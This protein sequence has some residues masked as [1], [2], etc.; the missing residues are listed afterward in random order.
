MGAALF[1]EVDEGVYAG[2]GVYDSDGT[3]SR[4]GFESAF[5]GRN[6]SVTLVELG[7]RPTWTWDAQ[8]LGG[9]YY[10]GGWYHSGTWERFGEPDRR[11]RPPPTRRGNAGLYVGIDQLV[12][13]ER[14][15]AEDDSQ[16]LGVFGQWGW[17]PSDVN[18]ISGYYGVGAQYV[19]LLPTRDDDVTGLGVFHV[20][21][22]G[23]AQSLEGRYSE[24]AVELFHKFQLTPAIG[25][26]PDLQYI[27][28]PG[29]GGR[30]AVAVGVRVEIS[31]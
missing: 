29:G 22:S 21:L 27:V 19:G 18:E 1:V 9:R 24:T 7:V 23:R 25:V 26:K 2:I 10:A 8:E 31:F 6:D 11:D 12:Y 16:G 15:R 13:R 4:W 5:H 20:S 14:P 17:S 3:G 28:N 30:D